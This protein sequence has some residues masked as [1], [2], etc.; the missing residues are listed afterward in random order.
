MIGAELLDLLKG[1]ETTSNATAWALLELSTHPEIQERLREE[2]LSCHN[3]NPTID[4]VNALPYLDSVAR[5]TLRLHA[6]VS[7]ITR[8]A[9]EDDII[10]FSK[11]VTLEN[12]D[13]VESMR[14]VLR[15][16]GYKDPVLTH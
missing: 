11:P 3:D 16:S 13:V 7:F 14:Y 2:L 15:S 9:L 8:Q 4:E 12:G 10:P 1:H 6:V 5:E